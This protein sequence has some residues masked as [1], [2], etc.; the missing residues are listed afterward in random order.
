MSVK[1]AAAVGL[2]MTLQFLVA[3][4]IEAQ[5]ASTVLYVVRHAERAEDGTSDP[6]LSDDGLVR[7]SQLARLLADSDLNAVYPRG[8]E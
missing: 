4:P 7:A 2:W 5:D 8:L 3:L 6:P 1:R